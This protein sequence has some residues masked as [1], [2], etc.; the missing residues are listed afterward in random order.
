MAFNNLAIAHSNSV[1]AGAVR[2][3][4]KQRIYFVEYNSD[5]NSN[6]DENAEFINVVQLCKKLSIHLLANASITCTKKRIVFQMNN[7]INKPPKVKAT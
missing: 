3:T 6:S 1:I 5:Y 4:L 7:N 2:P